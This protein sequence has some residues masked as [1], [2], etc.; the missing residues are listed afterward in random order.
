MAMTVEIKNLRERIKDEQGQPLIESDPVIQRRPDGTI[1]VIGAEPLPE[2]KQ[3]TVGSMLLNHLF[4][5]DVDDGVEAFLLGRV[6]RRLGEA[7]EKGEAYVAGEPAVA[8]LRKALTQNKPKTYGGIMAQMWA[9]VGTGKET[10]DEKDPDVDDPASLATPA[11][12]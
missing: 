4:R 9:T 12:G 11:S 10:D 8:L 5:M 2:A 7:Y 6:Q 3:P 1:T